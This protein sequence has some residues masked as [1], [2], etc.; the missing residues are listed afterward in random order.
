[1][2]VSERFLSFYE[3]FKTSINAKER[4]ETIETGPK[5]TKGTNKGIH[6]IFVIFGVLF[7]MLGVFFVYFRG[8]TVGQ[9]LY[10]F[11]GFL[12]FLGQKKWGNLCIYVFMYILVLLDF[13]KAFDK[14]SHAKL[15]K[16][17]KAYGIDGILVKWIE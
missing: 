13:A 1:M 16:K 2:T 12:Y 14:V 8:K 15:I 3:R 17:L 10:F 9:I 6:F 4:H 5:I 7:L 11:G